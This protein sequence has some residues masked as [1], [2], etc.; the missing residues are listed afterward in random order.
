MRYI[1]DLGGLPNELKGT[2]KNFKLIKVQELVGGPSI[3]NKLL[4]AKVKKIIESINFDDIEA[5]G[6]G[7]KGLNLV[8]DSVSMAVD[9]A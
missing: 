6:D 2:T 3:D 8:K 9:P 7:I 4:M 5:M 1:S